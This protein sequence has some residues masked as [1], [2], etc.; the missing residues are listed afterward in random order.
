MIFTFTCFV[1][2]HFLQ[3]SYSSEIKWPYALLLELCN[4]M[5]SNKCAKNVHALVVYNYG[6][7]RTWP[8]C[9]AHI[10]FGVFKVGFMYVFSRLPQIFRKPT[11]AIPGRNGGL[12]TWG[13][14]RIFIP[15]N[16]LPV[17]GHLD[18]VESCPGMSF[19][20]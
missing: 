14:V 4:N 9:V 11:M 17:L 3:N 13:I 7:L 19:L 12:F 20:G 1:H 8:W 16:F 6:P 5:T 18:R 2:T 10:L 15:Q